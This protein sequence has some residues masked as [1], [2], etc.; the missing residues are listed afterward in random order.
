MELVISLEFTM[1]Q[2]IQLKK[3]ER[4][5]YVRNPDDSFNKEML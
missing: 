2:R 4:L 1:K 5:I 3:I